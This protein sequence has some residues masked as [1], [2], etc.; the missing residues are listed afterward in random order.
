MGTLRGGNTCLRLLLKQKF[1]FHSSPMAVNPFCLSFVLSW[2]IFVEFVR[3]DE[4]L[5]SKLYMAIV[6]SLKYIYY[7]VG[8]VIYKVNLSASF[9]KIKRA[10]VKS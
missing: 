1:D 5:R 6:L 3:D 10:E 7:L 4:I 8:R 2:L 9:H